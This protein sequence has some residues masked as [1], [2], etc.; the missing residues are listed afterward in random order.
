MV[1]VIIGCKKRSNNVMS[2]LFFISQ[3]GY[4]VGECKYFVWTVQLFS[5]TGGLRWAFHTES[6]G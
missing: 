5:T 4:N 2:S 6:Y 1:L 3:S